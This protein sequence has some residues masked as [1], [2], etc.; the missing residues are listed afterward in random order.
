VA[1]LALTLGACISADPR[2]TPTPQPT[3]TP[4][5][6][7]TPVPPNATPTPD[8][9]VLLKDGG[10]GIVQIAYDRLLN[11][12]IRPLEPAPLLNAAWD[13]MAQEAANQGV[14]LPP[15]PAFSGDRSAQFVAF[16]QAYVPAITAAGEEAGTQLRYAAVRSMAASLNDCHT[17]FLSPVASDTLIETRAGKGSVGIGIEMSGAPPLITEVI[18][19]GPA[20]AAGM[21]IGDRIIRVDGADASSYGPAAALDAINGDEGT[22]VTVAVTRPGAAEPIEFTLTRQRVLPPNIE[23]RMIDERT[24]YVRIRN[25]VD[26]GIKPDLQRA[27]EGF[28][29]G[30]QSWII[31]LR[32]NPGG[33]LDSQAISLFIREGVIVRDRG[34]DGK[35]EEIRATGDLLMDVKPTVLLTNSRTGSVAEIFAAA[36]KEY[37]VGY[38]IGTN[39]YGC[40]GYTDVREFGDG[41][42][43]AVTTHEHVGPV[44]NEPLNGIGVI[45]DMVVGRSEA[46]I[47]NLRDPQLDAAVAH[48]AGVT[49]PV[50]AAP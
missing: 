31:D 6:T 4:V 48:L 33:R 28:A 39:T 3:N 40:V 8:L 37:G 26:G 23:A 35:V 50:G 20:A 24:G 30:V 43:M 19:G 18:G 11:E 14:V 1:A 7:P 41:T 22:T 47:A 46:D 44:T 13:G 17:F 2:P 5:L 38:V 29:P 45:P 27:L 15:K 10:I 34:R 36:L 9:A 49:S 42:S 16:A 32:G 12:Y 25:F 21:Q